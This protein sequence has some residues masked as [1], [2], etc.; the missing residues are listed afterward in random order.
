MSCSTEFSEYLRGFT[1]IEVLIVLAIIAVLIVIAVPSYQ[2]GISQG[3]R[4]DG[5]AFA[6]DLAAREEAYFL[7]NGS[8]TSDL[9]T[10]SGLN[11]SVLSQER[12]YIGSVGPCEDG[13]LV[14]CFQVKVSALGIQRASDQTC[15]SLTITN[16]GERG[17]SDS[18]GVFSEANSGARCW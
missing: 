8:Y 5:R 14:N 15:V 1:L 7:R 4:A 10:E 16:T 2:A 13:D 18:M 3:R 6:L 17:S 9:E 12:F 11:G